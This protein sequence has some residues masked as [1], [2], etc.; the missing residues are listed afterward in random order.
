MDKCRLHSINIVVQ[1]HISSTQLPDKILRNA[2][3]RAAPIVSSYPDGGSWPQPATVMH[4]LELRS[5]KLCSMSV[6]TTLRQLRHGPLKR[7]GPLWSALGEV[8][9]VG[10]RMTG[11]SRPAAHR[12]GGYGP[13]LLHGEFAFS[14]FENWGRGHNRGFASCIEA[15]RGKQCVLDIGA[16]I[17]LIAL[18]MSAVI[19]EGG[20]VYAFEPAAANLDRLRTHVALNGVSGIEVVDALVGDE[21]VDETRFFEQ[22]QATGMNATVI[23]KDPGA[24]HETRR[25]QVTL[26]RFCDERRLKPE[27]VKIDVEGAE[28]G[29][30]RG[31]AKMLRRCRPLVFLSVH[32]RHLALLGHTTGEL[33]ALVDDLGYEMR[34]IDGTTPGNLRLDE[35][36]VVPRSRV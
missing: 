4:L 7:F 1:A 8:Y 36:L 10:L 31:A 20:R 3:T 18:P 26:D 6:V 15:C 24:F 11:S 13:F 14:D 23:T 21:D 16:H 5:P 28:I 35:Y 19:A 33:E 22:S 30:L 29:V 2:G 27:V 17:G 9:Q 25:R 12:I 34:E 32:P